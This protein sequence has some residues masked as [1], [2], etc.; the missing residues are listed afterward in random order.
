MPFIT[1]SHLTEFSAVGPDAGGK[2]YAPS[3]LTERD[4]LGVE[5]Q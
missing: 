2:A 1:F 3:G 4:W 5:R